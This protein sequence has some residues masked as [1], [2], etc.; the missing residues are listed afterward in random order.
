MD[1]IT[2]ASNNNT[3]KFGNVIFCETNVYI[4]VLHNLFAKKSLNVKFSALFN[5]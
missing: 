2:S 1:Q 3:V 5:K 4:F